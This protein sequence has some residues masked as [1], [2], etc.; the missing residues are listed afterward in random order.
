VHS[1]SH[2]STSRSGSLDT[3]LGR[4]RRLRRLTLEGITICH[5]G[6][7]NEHYPRNLNIRRA[8]EL[9]GARVIT[10]AAT[11]SIPGAYSRIFART[12]GLKFDLAIVGWPGNA[13][14]PLAYALGK[15]QRA[16]VVLDAMT[17][18]WETAI[19][20]R[21]VVASRSITDRYIRAQER[22]ATRLA[23]LVLVDTDQHRR[24]FADRYKLN[25]RKLARIWVGSDEETWRRCD[26]VHEPEAHFRVVFVGSFIPLHGIER[27]VEAAALVNARDP[28]VEFVLIGSGQA[29]HA[30]RERMATSGIS[31]VSLRG[32]LPGSLSRE[33]CC[34]ADLCLG[35][36][37]T[38]EKTQRVIPNKVFDALAMGRPILTGDTPA[39][40][41]ALQPDWNVLAC[42]VG[43]AA[44]I[45][46]RILWA[47]G[48][49]DHLSLIAQRGHETFRQ[50][51]QLAEIS[52]DLSAALAGVLR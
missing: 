52:K 36:F 29:E 21:R 23:D 15:R 24:F 3:E 9:A 30:V 14:M 18:H 34:N 8:L 20:D 11:G 22:A 25:A 10:V 19:I 40:R 44:A 33:E 32:R 37:G 39:I 41:E 16:P 17:S 26:E 35:V 42:D 46:D 4:K 51:F 1:S 31:N 50:R 12:R 2:S 43:D 5:L 38:S 6:R 48:H 49:R 28:E 47:K 7:F 45:A 27:I 13:M